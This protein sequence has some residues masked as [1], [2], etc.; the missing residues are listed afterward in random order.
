MINFN[1]AK[2]DNTTAINCFADSQNMQTLPK[3]VNNEN[4]KQ[5]PHIIL[6]TNILPSDIHN[7][8]IS[9]GV[10]ND[11]IGINHHCINVMSTD[12]I[13]GARY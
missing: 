9:T 4:V 5:I 1:T 13:R 6:A 8:H 3:N 12:I 2:I 11:L 7:L 10:V